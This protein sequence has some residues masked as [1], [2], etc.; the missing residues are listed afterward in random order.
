MELYHYASCRLYTIAFLFTLFQEV[1]FF[2]DR[3]PSPSLRDCWKMDGGSTLV[4]P[5]FPLLP[6]NKRINPTFPPIPLLQGLQDAYHPHQTPYRDPRPLLQPI[7]IPFKN[8]S[9]CA[10]PRKG[11]LYFSPPPPPPTTYPCHSHI[12][13]IETMEAH[14]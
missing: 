14:S 5:H 9:I 3:R 1:L 2:V 6:P 12:G 10:N 7:I 13:T 8:L 4:A 11:P